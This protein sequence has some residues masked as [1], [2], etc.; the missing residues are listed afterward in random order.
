MDHSARWDRTQYNTIQ[1]SFI[2]GSWKC[3]LTQDHTWKEISTLCASYSFHSISLWSIW[4][5]WLPW[6]K[7]GCWLFLAI[8][9]VLKMLWH[10]ENL[11]WESMENILK[12]V[13]S[14]KRLIVKQYR[15][16]FQIFRCSVFQ[17]G[18]RS[19]LLSWFQPIFTGKKTNNGGMM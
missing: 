10:F 12:C 19:T 2:I 5:N 14:W 15:W 18:I 11:T 4:A 13:I 8:G 9:Q 1:L 6:F 16:K 17:N 3:L 7:T